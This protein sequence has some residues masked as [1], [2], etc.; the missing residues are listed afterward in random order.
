MLDKDNG[1]DAEASGQRPN[2]QSMNVTLQ[3]EEK[4]EN[5]AGRLGAAG[6]QRIYANNRR[7]IMLEWRRN[8]RFQLLSKG[9][10]SCS[11]MQ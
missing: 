4:Q 8:W 1:N 5:T 3:S 9:R 11:A 2:D 10:H 6:I 7:Q